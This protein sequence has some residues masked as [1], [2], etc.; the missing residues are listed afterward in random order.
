MLIRRY[1]V[2]LIFLLFCAFITA[3]GTP[4][5]TGPTP[6][7][8]PPLVT[9]EKSIY[10][11]EIGSIEETSSVQAEI[12]PMKQD[13]LFFR[14]SGFA[15]RV[16]VKKGDSVKAGD[17]LAEQ[18]VDDLLSQLEQARIDLQVAQTA[19]DRDEAQR[20]YAIIR[21]EHEVK[22]WEI[23]VKRAQL[24]LDNALSIKEK[25]QAQLD[26]D[27]I[28]EN[29]ELAKLT[30]QQANEESNSY[31]QQGVERT[32]LTVERLEAQISER[33]IFAPYD[34]IILSSNLRAGQSVD[35]F[36][37]LFTVGDPSHLVL[38]IRP[39]NGI[40]ESINKETKI[41]MYLSSEDTQGYSINYLPDFLL[42]NSVDS[43]ST[44]ATT[45]YLYF[46]YP[47]D[48]QESAIVGRQ[49]KLVILLGHKDN[50]LLLPPAGVRNY[51]GL[52]FVIILD[53]DKKRR[54]DL[55]EVG[56]KTA[57][58]WEVSGDLKAGDQVLGP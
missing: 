30:Q 11:V 43:E 34:C 6:T 53:G 46:S 19:F 2:M 31:Q 25:E 24:N 49:V 32:Q 1:K 47:V 40:K 33:Q 56:L 18:Q 55:Y 50:V 57:E 41:T 29:L 37:P 42:F 20:K 4:N 54:V 48:L 26:L 7:P 44:T 51:R 36:V 12:V 16:V 21:A 35:A 45:E 13:D 58:R 27:E 39:E 14:A 10:T 22:I 28:K 15:N 17:L 38:R 9:Y 3:C 5:K 52:N 8:L 23:K